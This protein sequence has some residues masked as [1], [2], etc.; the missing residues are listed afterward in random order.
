MTIM[1]QY[2]LMSLGQLN[3]QQYFYMWDKSILPECTIYCIFPKLSVQAS[4]TNCK[5]LISSEKL[6]VLLI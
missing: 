5:L 4:T 2:P 6:S 1:K 3:E